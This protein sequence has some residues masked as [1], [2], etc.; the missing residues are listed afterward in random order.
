MRQP[1]ISFK[2]MH[3]TILLITIMSESSVD[4]IETVTLTMHNTTT[5]FRHIVRRREYTYVSSTT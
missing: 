5:Y 1:S 4:Y 2:E 3:D